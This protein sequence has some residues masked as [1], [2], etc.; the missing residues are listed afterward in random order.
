MS[1]FRRYVDEARGSGALCCDPCALWASRHGVVVDV[2]PRERAALFGRLGARAAV[3]VAKHRFGML[4]AMTPEV[5]DVALVEISGAAVFG[6][7]VDAPARRLPA[8][9]MFDHGTGVLRV[10]R[11]PMLLA[12]SVPCR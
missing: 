1:F 4:V 8:V 3:D 6:I 11:A 10:A 2:P 7:V 12:W 9:A 5:G